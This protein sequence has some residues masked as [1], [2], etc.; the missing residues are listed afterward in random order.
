MSVQSGL[1]LFAKHYRQCVAGGIAASFAILLPILIGGTGLAL[2]VGEST[3]VRQRLCSALDASVLAGASSSMDDDEIEDTIN[4]FFDG[5]YPE[6]AIGVASDLDVDV[7]DNEVTASVTADYETRFMR[8]LG[9]ET[10][11]IGCSTTVQRNVKGLE[12]VMVLDNTGSMAGSNITSLKTSATNLVNILFDTV[13]DPEDVRIGLVPYSASVNVGPYGIGEDMDGN[14]YGTAFVN[15]PGNKDYEQRNTSEWNGCV[16]AN[17]YDDD[18]TDNEGP[19]DMYA[20]YYGVESCSGRGRRRSC[21]TYYYWSAC[22]E[23]ITP[24]T[25]NQQ[26]LIDAIDDMDASGN[27][28]GNYGMVWGYRVISPDYPFEEAADY[29]DPEWNK[30]IIMMTDGDNQMGTYTAYGYYDDHG[31]N[32]GDLNDR[33]EDVC[34]NAKAD[35]IIIYTIT[36]TSGISESTKDYYRECATDLNHYYDAPTQAELEDVFEDIA[37]ALAKLHIKN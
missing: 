35:G 12:V 11:T 14:A 5:N 24:I 37:Y 27:T 7:T 8:I 10:I 4:E 16:L 25:S 26:T 34:E 32:N 20:P 6:D 3:H 18:V 21:D 28:L 17:D 15:N 22:P 36:F 19:W 33:F 2:D 13:S 1:R 23:P 9:R 30:A 29:D 31:L